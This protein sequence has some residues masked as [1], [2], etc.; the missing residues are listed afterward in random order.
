MRKVLSYS[1]RLL[2][3]SLCHRIFVLSSK[4]DHMKI[5]RMR[6]TAEIAFFP[7]SLFVSALLFVAAGC[8]KVGEPQPPV[9]LLP[10][11][12]TD[13]AARQYA[14][15][16]VLT[17]STPAQNTNGSPVTTLQEVE[18]FR[19][20][21]GRGQL[22]VPLPK[23]DYL[24]RATK[25]L[26][27]TADK[28][29]NY[30][31]E[32]TFVFWDEF[33]PQ[34]RATIYSQTFDYAVRFV[35]RKKQTAGLGNLAIVSPV[36]IPAA[37]TGLTAK[38]AQEYVRLS[39][40]P[41]TQNMDGSVPPRFEG[42]NVYRSEDPK[43][44]A[45]GPLN[46]DLLPK[47]EFEDRSFQF[48]KTYYYAVSVVGSRQDPYAESLR[49]QPVEVVARDSF[50]PGPPQNL[51]AVV[52]N[53]IVILLWAAPLDPDVAGYRIYRSEEGGKEKQLLQVV[54]MNTLSF[55]DEKAQPGKKYEYS[56]SAVDTHGNESTRAY[57]TAEVP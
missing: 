5:R 21:A 28:F 52:E 11:P 10:K 6:R 50:P 18:V 2:C 42:Y 24:R 57:T 16:I 27:V 13:L 26:A 4:K 36:A 40:N 1:A 14:D 19:V 3:A 47:P 51:N 39:W 45:P 32:K 23:E 29:S 35:N 9:L 46:S 41:P 48:D 20:S 54:P 38:L 12:A 25:I 31:N 37:P 33:S 34:E 43:K 30:L 15:K 49:S 55:R 44:F 8:A 17:V 53:G 22:K 7:V 56:V